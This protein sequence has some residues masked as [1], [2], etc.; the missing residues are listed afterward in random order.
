MDAVHHSCS[1]CDVSSSLV[2]SFQVERRSLMTDVAV[3]PFPQ[4]LFLAFADEG[5][6]CLRLDR[7]RPVAAGNSNHVTVYSLSRLACCSGYICVTL[8]ESNSFST[9]QAKVL[10]PGLHV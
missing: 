4:F 5:G 7:P 8:F 3:A 6:R 10:G 2:H 1:H 9:S